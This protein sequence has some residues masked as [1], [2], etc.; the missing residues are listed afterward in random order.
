MFISGFIIL[1]QLLNPSLKICDFATMTTYE[2]SMVITHG[3]ILYNTYSES[4]VHGLSY[5]WYSIPQLQIAR[6]LAQFKEK[7]WFRTFWPLLITTS[8]IFKFENN[9]YVAYEML[10]RMIPNLMGLS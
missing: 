9:L 3:T 1:L 6:P 7:L 4:S 5:A 2:I 10:F 8:K